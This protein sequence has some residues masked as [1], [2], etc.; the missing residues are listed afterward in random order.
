MKLLAIAALISCT[1]AGSVA[2][3]FT[4]Y[5][6]DD[7]TPKHAC[8]LTKSHGKPA[9]F[10]LPVADCKLK[11]GEKA[12]NAEMM[13]DNG[14]FPMNWK[15]S[16]AKPTPEPSDGGYCEKHDDCRSGL[17]CYEVMNKNEPTIY[18]WICLDM[19]AEGKYKK[20]SEIKVK[21]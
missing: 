17:A 12:G 3:Y 4:C 6:G 13:D 7:C 11:K 9:N 1:Q 18:N 21:G 16:K 19:F 2:K 14:C 10:C 5:K 20:G 8:R 15:A